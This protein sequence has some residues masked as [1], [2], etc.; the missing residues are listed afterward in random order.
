MSFNPKG[1]GVNPVDN[2]LPF[3]AKVQKDANA[4]EESVEKKPK[5]R[6]EPKPVGEGILESS[7]PTPEFLFVECARGDSDF[8]IGGLTEDGTDVDCT[9]FRWTDDAEGA[10]W[11]PLAGKAANAEALKWL[12][13]KARNRA[14][15]RT[16]GSCVDTAAVAFAGDRD[17]WLP[18]SAVPTIGLRGGYLQ[19]VKENDVVFLRAQKPNRAAGL[20]YVVPVDFDQNRVNDDGHYIPATVPPDSRFGS[21]LNRFLPDLE[22]RALVQ[23]A[24]GSTILP[25]TFEKA[26]WLQGEGSNG[27]STML[28]LLRALHPKNAALSIQQLG[29]RFGLV[30]I[31]G[32]TLVTVSECPAFIGADAEQAIKAIVSRD[33]IPVEKKGADSITV[34]PRCT[35]FLLLNKALRIV[36]QSYGFWSKALPLPFSVQLP[37]ND[38]ARVPDFHKLIVDDPKEMAH[39]VDWVLEGAVRL[40]ARG[41]F[42]KELP[43]A[44]Q[45][46][47]RQQ[48]V[49]ADNVLQYL[50]AN[51]AQPDK[52]ILTLR[53]AVYADYGQFCKD[54][55]V[56]PVSDTEFWTRVRSHFKG[57]ELGNHRM[58]VQENGKRPWAVQLRVDGV[59][60]ASSRLA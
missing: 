53:P 38:P 40:E 35:L 15:A 7:G 57:T 2:V 49:E 36:D 22:V 59:A 3:G 50:E 4:S 17:K 34:V 8:R 41:N 19:L 11:V 21:Y 14:S 26:F 58:P 45:A 30:Q 32:K 56:H 13:D 60:P 9:F 37:R 52:A 51:N 10:R 20:S 33:A 44:V 46:L 18:R 25:R 12:F 43:A 1:V 5:K 55:N 28:H 6:K 27:K 47:S 48:R 31:P 24:V 39:F 16:A 42:P 23:E 29:T 54:C